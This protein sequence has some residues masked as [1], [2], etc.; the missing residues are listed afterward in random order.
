MYCV[1]VIDIKQFDLLA[2]CDLKGCSGLL[3]LPTDSVV[4]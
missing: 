1:H 3:E 2:S 4:E